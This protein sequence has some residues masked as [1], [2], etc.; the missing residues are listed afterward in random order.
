[1][2]KHIQVF[3]TTNRFNNDAPYANATTLEF[4]VATDY[5]PEIIAFATE[6]IKRI[7]RKGFRYKKCG[8]MMIDLTAKNQPQF[9]MF[10]TQ[11]RD[12]QSAAM[13]ALDRINTRWGAGTLFYAGLGIRRQWAMKRELKSPHYTTEWADLLK[14]S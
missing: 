12:K 7:F 9:D 6:G 5:T 3:L 4:P 10:D 8:L 13:L 1:M 11:D 2:A 14:V